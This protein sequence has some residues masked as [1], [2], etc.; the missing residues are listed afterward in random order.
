MTNRSLR[1][2]AFTLIELLV[3]I[4]IIA[5]LA[6]ILFPVFARARE[7]ARRSSCQSNLKQIGL[8]W[9]QYA[10][11]YDERAL[12]ARTGGNPSPYFLWHEVMQPYI[13][14]KQLMVCPSNTAGT[15]LSYT[16]NLAS[17]INGG[18][19]LAGFLL[20]AQMPIFADARGTADTTQ[21]LFFSMNANDMVGRFATA[22]VNATD[23]AVGVIKADIH[24]ETA[25]YL[26]A[27]G[28]VKAQKSIGTIPCTGGTAPA[29]PRVDLDFNNDGIVGTATAYG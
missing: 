24:L 7:N 19:A 3:V 14:S 8:G 4:A 29:P 22:G 1:P 28:H 21:A 23:N 10:Q 20:P 15:S 25:N 11:D 13:K 18:V 5:I 12:P 26:F 9:L 16:Y 17:G 2:K 6:A 27:D